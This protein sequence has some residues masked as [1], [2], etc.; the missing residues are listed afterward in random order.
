MTS[1]ERLIAIWTEYGLPQ[2]RTTIDTA[3]KILQ[4]QRDKIEELHRIIDQ[5]GSTS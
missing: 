4:R 3:L 1:D 2:D 5:L